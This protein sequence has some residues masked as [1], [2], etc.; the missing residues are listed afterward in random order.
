MVE[1]ESLAELSLN[2]NEKQIEYNND[3]LSFDV[4]RLK[5]TIQNHVKFTNS[6][7]GKLIL[8]NW[9]KYLPLFVKITPFEFKRA[10]NDRKEKIMIN[11]IAG[12]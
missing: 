10:L 1:L 4:S 11:K 5:I 8:N 7:K 9:E 3:L 12:E 6:E 2:Q